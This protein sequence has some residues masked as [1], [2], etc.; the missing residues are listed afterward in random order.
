MSAAVALLLVD[1][2]PTGV[3]AARCALALA[4][5]GLV[6]GGSV[7]AAGQLRAL[8]LDFAEVEGEDIAAFRRLV[9][10][11][12]AMPCATN[13]RASAPEPA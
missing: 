7:P 4:L 1:M 10:T 2:T 13:G 11:P 6:D 12:R 3:D 9:Q 5:A 8:L